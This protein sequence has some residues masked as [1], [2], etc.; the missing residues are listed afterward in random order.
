MMRDA[1][2]RYWPLTRADLAR[3]DSAGRV[4]PNQ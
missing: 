3:L 2:R 1:A 4:A